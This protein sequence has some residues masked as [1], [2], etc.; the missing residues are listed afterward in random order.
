MFFFRKKFKFFGS[1]RFGNSYYVING[2][3][4]IWYSSDCDVT[5]ISTEWFLWLH[6]ATDKLPNQNQLSRKEYR[7]RIPNLTG[8]ADAY[9]PPQSSIDH[10][11]CSYKSWNPNG[12]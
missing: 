7:I 4:E 3:R 2:K 8:T 5:K 12:D 6:Y 9:M 11:S 10:K 1:D